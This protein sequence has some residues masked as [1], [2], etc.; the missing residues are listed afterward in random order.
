MQAC[1]FINYVQKQKATSSERHLSGP[2]TPPYL[3]KRSLT[4]PHLRNLRQYRVK[5]YIKYN[6]IIRFRHMRFK[7]YFYIKNSVCGCKFY[8]FT[9]FKFLQA[10]ICIAMSWQLVVIFGENM[11]IQGHSFW[12]QWQSKINAVF[13]GLNK[14]Q[15]L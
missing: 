12:Y 6:N 14:R 7:L 10:T 13:C 11:V 4:G 3:L 8:V 1:L 15:L 2:A 5:T 9:I